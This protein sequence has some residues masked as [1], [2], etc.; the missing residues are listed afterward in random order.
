MI[1]EKLQ[2]YVNKN[3]ENMS[4]DESASSEMKENI[5]IVNK[6]KDKPQSGIETKAN[7]PPEYT[8]K[9]E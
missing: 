8:S 5:N 9:H 1:I 3:K 4:K 7:F 6:I 2:S